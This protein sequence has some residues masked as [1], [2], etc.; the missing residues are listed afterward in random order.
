L[1]S[2]TNDLTEAQWNVPFAPGVNPIA[3]EIG[4]VAWFAQWWTLRG[5][6]SVDAQGRTVAAKPAPSAGLDALFDSSRIAHADRWRVRLPER[7]EV[8][9]ML[10]AQLDTTLA[11]LRE[12][13]EDDASLYFFRLALFHED[14]HNEALTWLRAAL[15]YPAP[16]GT[17]L[18]HVGEEAGVQHIA[19]HETVIGHTKDAG[20]FCFD[21]E[22]WAH[23]ARLEGFEIDDAPVSCGAF[24]RFVDAGGYDIAEYWPGEA[25]Q[26]R[27]A[28]ELPHPRNWKRVGTAWHMRWFDD[29]IALP[30][31]APVMQVNAFEAQAYCL[32]AK[33]RLPTAMQWEAAARQ[34]AIHWGNSVWEWTASTFV[35]Y[36]GFSRGPYREYS[37]PWF[38]N[39]REL[40]GGCFATDARL[41]HLQYRNFFMPHRT[42]VFAGFR[43]CAV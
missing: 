29:W 18:P 26:W 20:G 12:S 24:Q 13:A 22:Q 28:S 10:D 32:W 36:A 15:Y 25:G 19:E 9:S 40:R 5:P 14:M 35:P 7:S 34:G 31:D 8:I 3:W 11:A 21:N 6:H 23:S 37:D 33:R 38:G 39:H 27:R 41:H 2:L 16:Q 17:A 30:E 42:D 4:H 1:K 43:T